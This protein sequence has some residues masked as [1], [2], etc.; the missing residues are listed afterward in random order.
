MHASRVCDL[1]L[2]HYH[3]VYLSIGVRDL[4]AMGCPVY[5]DQQLHVM[6]DGFPCQSVRL[7]KCA[8]SYI[9]HPSRHHIIGAARTRR[10][11]GAN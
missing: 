7:D 4:R 8:P 9:G 11:S 6:V 1:R 10:F 3:L 5:M 2:D